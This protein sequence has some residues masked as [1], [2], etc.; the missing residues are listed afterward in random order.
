VQPATTPDAP[1]RAD[2]WGY[3]NAQEWNRGAIEDAG[4]SWAKKRADVTSLWYEQTMPL[5]AAA[6][7]QRVALDFT[8]IEGDALVFLN[9]QR[10]GELLRPGGEIDVTAQAIAGQD[11]R[12]QVFLTRSYT[13]ISR[14]FAADP[15][16]YAAR[17][18][19]IPPA[20]WQLGIT[21]PV[22]LILR[23]RPAAITDVFVI[24]SWRQKTLTLDVEVDAERAD[25]T[26]ALRAV[27]LDAEQKAVL[28]LQS[29][30]LRLPAGRSTQHV[31]AAW[32]HPIPWELDG[33]YLYTTRV[34]LVRGDDVA[35]TAPDVTFGFREIWAEGRQLLMNGHASRWRYVMDFG[36]QTPNALS[37]YQLLGGNIILFQPNPTSWW[38]DWPHE[39][40]LLDEQILSLLD[41]KGLGATALA[42]GISSLGSKLLSDPQT[43]RDYDR[44]MALWVRRYRNHPSIFAWVV[45]MNTYCP[46]SAMLPATLGR[47]LPAP[48]PSQAQTIAYACAVA[49]RHDPTRLTYS[50]ADGGLGDMANANTYLNFAPLQER[51]EW[52]MAWAKDGNMPFSAVEF[53]QPF[54]ANFWKDKRCL[55]TE[56]VAMY[57]G[58]QAY[59]TET[60][61]GLRRTKAYSL[62]NNRFGAMRAV[63]LADF[64]GYW[65]FQ[66]L[67][68]THTD[69]AWRTWGVNGGWFP[70]C[71]DTGYG[72]P[73]GFDV[74]RQGI[75]ARYES[76]REPVTEKPS[77][78]NPNFDIHQ[79][80]NRPLLAYLAGSPRHTDKTH[81]Y[82]AGERITKQI[83]V[84]W[85]GPGSRTL[86]ARWELT[87]A[88]GGPALQSGTVTLALNA[89]D[90]SLRPFSS[91]APAVTQRTACVLT[92]TVRDG[93]QTVASDSLPLTVFPAAAP[94]KLA[95]RVAVYDPK[96]LTTPWLTRLGIQAAPFRAGQSCAN[97]DLL[98]IGREALRIGT[99]LPYT[100]ADL[101]RGLRVLVL[102]QQPD[103]WQ[104]M[105]Y[106]TLA[107]MPRYVFPRDKQSPIL[108]GLLPEDLV[109]WRGTPDLLPEGKPGQSYDVPHAPK[110]TNTH[111]VASVVLQIPQV[112]GVTPVLQ[113]EFDLDYSPLLQWR[114]G[115]GALYCSSLDFTGRV[116]VDP[117]A[118]RLAVNLL[119]TAVEPL[120][121]LRSVGYLGGPRGKALLA[122]LNLESVAGTPAGDPAQALVVV[123][124]GP[125]PAALDTFVDQGGTAVYLPRSA[126]ELGGDG[127]HASAQQFVRVAPPEHPLFRAIGPGLLRWR[128]TLDSPLFLPDGQPDKATVLGN[129]LFLLRPQGK[130][131]RV[132]CQL[133]PEQLRER[134]PEKSPEREAVELSCLRMDQCYAQLLT[135]AGAGAS[136]LCANRLLTL[137]PGAAYETLGHWQVLGPFTVER[138]DSEL[139]LKTAFPGE[140][141]AIAG[142]TNPNTLYTRADGARLDWR[143]SVTAD[144]DGF[145]DLGAALGASERAVAYVTRVLHCDQARLARL[146]LGVDYRLQVWING[147]SV[148]RLA[149]AHG[150]PTANRHLVDVPLHAG[151]NVITLKIGAGGKGFGF[152]ANIS[153]T[154]ATEI[155][156]SQQGLQSL[157]YDTTLQ[158]FDP[159]QYTHW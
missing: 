70:W 123:G 66:R 51:E 42:P 155:I 142:N 24:P 13:G 75:F 133:P 34:S 130:G 32:A 135:N 121:P 18:G 127:L 104:G 134:Y 53:G 23:P 49:K 129:G 156:A 60:E 108:A 146:R 103:V 79:Q 105:G 46:E 145:V 98:I 157:F 4:T 148:Y 55:I 118:T 74:K 90:I 151:D 124:E 85:D 64:P 84:V 116:G 26:Y 54:E 132:Y 25:T 143:K 139:M 38:K 21:A 16:R 101:A 81:S 140:D 8:R 43:Q 92:L 29:A 52:P 47:Q 30:P 56:Y 111:A 22:R 83:A 59:T 37:F 76:L 113:T 120:P 150:A 58:D 67:F 95:A 36:G 5:P 3:S 99:A 159:Y 119:R 82:F 114:I 154:D 122:R 115:K 117:A 44:E 136:T 12:L 89:G 10:V 62:A 77:W 86:V 126:E 2:D 102:E 93:A 100:Q 107:S 144:A 149:S 109:N 9:G 63:D 78:A 138:D 96:A 20:R 39:S 14:G 11:N 45:G 57:L 141:D 48:L 71:L 152:W 69:R 61:T 6:Q 65:D 68:V 17:N 91:T 35:D 87:P 131:L 1:P 97:I 88:Q 41:A 33:G 28:T 158:T 7:G 94:L 147:T 80:N 19:Q 125:S 112:A 137:S 128:D 40:P 153:T 31:T 50:H 15:L 27:V 72:D 110:W 106:R 73:P